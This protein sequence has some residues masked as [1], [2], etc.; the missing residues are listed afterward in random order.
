M[1]KGE[2]FLAK[3]PANSKAMTFDRPLPGPA[4]PHDCAKSRGA[5]AK[6]FKEFQKLAEGEEVFWKIKT[7]P[8]LGTLPRFLGA[9]VRKTRS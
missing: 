2:E 6:V 3:K 7:F 9:W 8:N 4:G 5:N 1:L